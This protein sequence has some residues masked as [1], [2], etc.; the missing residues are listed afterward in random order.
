MWVWVFV[1]ACASICQ[2]GCRSVWVHILLSLEVPTIARCMP[3]WRLQGM[4][5]PVDI[6]SEVVDR[7]L[8][9][10]YFWNVPR[11]WVPQL[12]PSKHSTHMLITPELKRCQKG[13]TCLI[14]RG[15][16]PTF[17]HQFVISHHQLTRFVWFC[18]NSL[19]FHKEYH[20]NK[21]GAKQSSSWSS[22]PFW[23]ISL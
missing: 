3:T 16:N 4:C 2:F 20:C 11:V 9:K 12:A 15:V 17:H 5:W 6:I 13:H 18:M 14:A 8:N 19:H 22:T 21:N 7:G 23:P 10:G 1:C